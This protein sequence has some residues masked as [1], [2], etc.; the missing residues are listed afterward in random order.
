MLYEKLDLLLKK[1]NT[2]FL[3]TGGEGTTFF[4]YAKRE[5]KVGFFTFEF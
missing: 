2:Q 4:N 5:E 3:A 1:K